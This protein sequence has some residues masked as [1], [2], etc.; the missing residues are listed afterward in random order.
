MLLKRYVFDLGLQCSGVREF[1]SRLK[2]LNIA[3]FFFDF[4]SKFILKHLF[5]LPFVNLSEYFFLSPNELNLY[6]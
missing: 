5:K 3:Y 4:E 1:I 2:T 6:S